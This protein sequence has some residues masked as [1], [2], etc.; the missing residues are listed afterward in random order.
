MLEL[1]RRHRRRDAGAQGRHVSVMHR[2]PALSGSGKCC[3][4]INIDVN[5]KSTMCRVSS[6]R[7]PRAGR[8]CRGKQSVRHM[9][10]C[11]YTRVEFRCVWV[12][13]KGEWVNSETSRNFGMTEYAGVNCLPGNT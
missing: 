12:F 4:Y 1:V 11:K 10:N 2:P 3:C 7:P 6:R 8:V 13:V 9:Q 5:N